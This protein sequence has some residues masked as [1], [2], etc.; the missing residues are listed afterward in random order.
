MGQQVLRV[1]V[2]GGGADVQ[3][4]LHVYA[5]CSSTASNDNA[6]EP[7]GRRSS[8]ATVTL[9]FINVAAETHF[10]IMPIMSS[11]GFGAGSDASRLE[12]HL[13]APSLLS[14][15]VLLNGNPLLVEDGQLPLDK[16]V[17]REVPPAEPI[18]VAPL[19]YGFAV[20]PGNGCPTVAMGGG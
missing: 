1:D 14:R 10:A 13:T 4:N 2:T 9:L 16:L 3:N 5:H 18:S 15:V 6:P 7:T 20:L 11:G 19:S 12:Y 17:P 8:S